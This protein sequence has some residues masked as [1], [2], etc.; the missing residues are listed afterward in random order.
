MGTAAASVLL[1][2]GTAVASHAP[3]DA[4]GPAS[5]IGNGTAHV[6]QR[7]DDGVPV[8]IGVRIDA[9]ALDGLP[10]GPLAGSREYPLQVADRARATPVDHVT[11]D[12]N[13]HGHNPEH[14]FDRPHF[15]VHFYLV[16]RAML[17]QI[18]PLAPGYLDR[19]TRLPDQK[20]LPEGYAPTDDPLTGTTMHMG[21]H[22]A[23]SHPRPHEFTETVLHG[24]WDGRHIFIE[25]MFTRDW[26]L[27]HPSHEETLPQPQAYQA[28]GHY[29][30]TFSVDWDADA[31]QYVVELG[32]LAYHDAG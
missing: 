17:M 23:D 24:S 5:A 25:P 27:T 15:D 29:P 16:D 1:V 12:W 4:V 20:Y 18:D 30:T 3:P 2:S 9:A 6:F 7:F 13:P 19:A 8:A 10:E 21:L 32:G 28:S 14:G 11:M 22:W 26:L 31:Q